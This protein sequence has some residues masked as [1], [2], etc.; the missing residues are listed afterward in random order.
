MIAELP[1]HDRIVISGLGLTAPNGNTLAEFREALLAGR[2]GVTNYEIRYFG[3][4]LAGI[5]QFD[6]LRY[7]RR[8]DLRR[9]TRAGSIAIYCANEAIVD[10]GLEWSNV[11]KANVGVY[12][13]VTEHGNVETENEI[14]LLK[15]YD[16]DTK[17][18]SHHHN[19]RTVA[20]NPAGEITLN[21][22]ITGP[23]Y[24]LG[25]ACAAGNAGLIQGVQMLRLRE[26][27]MAL[28]GGVSESIHTFGIFASFASQGALAKH[29][30]PTKASRPFDL[31]RNGIVVAEGGC[32]FVLERLSDARARGAKLYGEI[33][34]Y[35]MNSDASDFVLPNPQR[36][37]ECVELALKRA[38]LTPEQIDIVS[39]HAT[40]TNSGD[41]QECQALRR[42]FQDNGHTLF[43][44]T[45]SFIGHAMGA[46]GA[47]ELAGNLPAFVDGVCHATINLDA[48]DPECELPGLVANQPRETG[49][50]DTILNNSFG[51]LGTNSVVIVR[52]V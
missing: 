26:C 49:R 47:L 2:S 31:E 30:D 45:K 7:Q 28:C 35:A 41:A 34:G 36:Q 8:K 22:G 46:A 43:N 32:M 11:E 6:E 39:T 21:L 1:D 5:C 3:P 51:M 27:D 12:V 9:G 52:K 17:F 4:T 18:W 16:Y 29:E 38:G 37:A 14:Y 40:G 50:I 15:G 44:N 23:H 13:G 10:S 33:C 24:T 25:A 19:P 48:L 42:V 20:N